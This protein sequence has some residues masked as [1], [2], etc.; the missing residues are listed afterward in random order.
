[1]DPISFSLITAT[2]IKGGVAVGGY[3][4]SALHS[5]TLITS[6]STVASAVSGAAAT[7]ATSMVSISGTS[8]G[9]AAIG[10][11]GAGGTIYL[12]T[13]ATKK[14][15]ILINRVVIAERMADKLRKQIIKK[16]N[17]I[18]LLEKKS[19]QDEIETK[20][21]RD[22]YEKLSNE[23]QGNLVDLSVCKN[24]MEECL[25]KIVEYENKSKKSSD[26]LIKANIEIKSLEQKLN[27][28]S[29][30]ISYEKNRSEKAVKEAIEKNAEIEQSNLDAKENELSLLNIQDALKT[31]LNECYDELEAANH[32]N[33]EQ[34]EIINLLEKELININKSTLESKKVVALLELRVNEK[35]NENM[36]LKNIICQILEVFK[37]T[38]AVSLSEIDAIIDRNCTPN[39]YNNNL[40]LF[41]KKSIKSI[42][43]INSNSTGFS[44]SLARSI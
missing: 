3:V 22:L 27:V 8:A 15:L 26:L 40:V 7:C 38:K 30:V 31:K 39:N 29:I 43:G 20:K 41:G 18:E 4:L 10:L 44:P 11:C 5:T 42:D 32:L 19:N 25:V 13:I 28:A 21:L 37:L 2:I 23:H 24:N 35:N 34:H 1:M 12:G 33:D 14:I 36:N 16:H 17:T 6:L 9:M